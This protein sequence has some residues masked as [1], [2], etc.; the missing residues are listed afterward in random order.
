MAKDIQ[1]KRQWNLPRNNFSGLYPSNVI[2][3]TNRWK[4]SSDGRFLNLFVNRLLFKRIVRWPF[5]SD[6]LKPGLP[7][8]SHVIY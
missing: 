5:Q 6:L 8:C 4:T 2:F 7:Q 1:K 3:K